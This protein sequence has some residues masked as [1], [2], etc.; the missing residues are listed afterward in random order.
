[1]NAKQL[2][3]FKKDIA[4]KFLK[5]L[6]AKGELEKWAQ[7]YCVSDKDEFFDDVEKIAY[8]IYSRGNNFKDVVVH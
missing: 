7:D 8:L 2:A 6:E 5:D 3:D 1:M 4:N